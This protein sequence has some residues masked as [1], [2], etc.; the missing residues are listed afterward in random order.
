MDS[1]AST[2]QDSREFKRCGICINAWVMLLSYVSWAFVP[3]QE[4]G[5]L[6]KSLSFLKQE[7]FTVLVN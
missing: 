3:F 2:P 7:V 4:V 6:D 5:A 1:I